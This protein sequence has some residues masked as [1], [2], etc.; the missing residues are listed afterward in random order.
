MKNIDCV[1]VYLKVEDT[2][3]PEIF[4]DVD[5]AREFLEKVEAE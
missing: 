5:E 1:I 2:T 4:Y 3:V